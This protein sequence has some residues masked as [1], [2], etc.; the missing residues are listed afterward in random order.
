MSDENQK[1]ITSITGNLGLTSLIP[2]ESYELT[3]LYSSRSSGF[4]SSFQPNNSQQSE[5]YSKKK[6]TYSDYCDFCKKKGHKKENCWKIIGYPQGFKSKKKGGV[7]AYNVCIEDPNQNFYTQTSAQSGVQMQRQPSTSRDSS[8]GR[9]LVAYTFTKEQYEQI[10]QMLNKSSLT[11]SS[12]NMAHT[13]KIKPSNPKK[14]LY[15]GRVKEIGKEHDGLYMLIPHINKS[16]L[17]IALTVKDSTEPKEKQDIDLWH[18]RLGHHNKYVKNIRTDNGLEFINSTYSDL[19]SNL[20]MIHQKTCVYTP[21]QNG[22]AER[23]HIHILEVARAM[24]FQAH[25]PLKYWGHFQEKD[26]FMSRAIPAVLMGYGATQKGYVLLNLTNHSFFVNMDVVFKATIF[27]FRH[28]RNKYLPIFLKPDVPADYTQLSGVPTVFDM[29]HNSEHEAELTHSDIRDV[30]SDTNEDVHDNDVAGGS[31]GESFLAHP[32]GASSDQGQV[33]VPST[34]QLPTIPS[35]V[36]EEVRRSSRPNNPPIC[37]KDFVSLNVH[38]SITEGTVIVLVYV[39][40]MLVTG[41]SLHLIEET[42]TT[43]QQT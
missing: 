25:I 9:Q 37:I 17:D 29:G 21:Q 39:D 36:E 33:Q 34:Q 31:E 7:A 41:T 8:S 4:Q 43:L 42:K 10:L 32:T 23:K 40:D 38:A 15:S 11:A 16:N 30:S 6:R 5:N 35:A 22:V 27:P 18:M 20:G 19:F 14:D 3:A 12:A 2:V 28:T 24:R 1:S 13:K 26:K